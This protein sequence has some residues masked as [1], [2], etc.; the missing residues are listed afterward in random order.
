MKVMKKMIGQLG[1]VTWSKGLQ[2]EW[3]LKS[4]YVKNCLFQLES[5]IIYFSC[6]SLEQPIE[7]IE[8]LEDMQGYSVSEWVSLLAPRTEIL[9]RFKNFIRTYTDSKGNAIYKEKLRHMCEGITKM[10]VRFIKVSLIFFVILENKSSFELDYNKLASVE[11]VL[12]Y[13]LPE[14]PLEMLAIFDEATKEIV[15]AMFPQYERIAKEIHVR[16]TDLPLVED[17]RSLR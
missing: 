5:C 4:K 6:V 10:D 9:N 3:M 16:I 2:K 1:N 8:N 7:S 12:A 15:L 17:I 13:F 11:H 14:A